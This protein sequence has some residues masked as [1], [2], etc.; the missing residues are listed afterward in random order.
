MNKYLR[1]TPK[2]LSSIAERKPN[3]LTKVSVGQAIAKYHEA[4]D[5]GI[6]EDTDPITEQEEIFAQCMADGHT[7]ADSYR[8]AYPENIGEYTELQLNRMAY[9]L[10][11][12]GAVIKA[13]LELMREGAV[14]KYHTAQRL[15]RLRRTVLEQI[16]SDPNEKSSDRIRALKQLGELDDV[17]NVSRE[18]A[19]ELTKQSDPQTILDAI[20][21][22]I[23]E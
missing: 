13:S 16:A 9:R 11:K 4:R 19:E 14:S 23:E 1:R 20:Y 17:R 22:V 6:I 2:N 18:D 8:I 12:K 21:K 15:Q 7:L 10:A 5:Q 3:R